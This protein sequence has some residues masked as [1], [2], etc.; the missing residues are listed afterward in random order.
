MSS[1]RL[2]NYSFT[3]EQKNEYFEKG[4]TSI[5]NGVSSNLLNRLQLMAE[6][7]EKKILDKYNK[8]IETPNA[9]ILENKLIRYNSIIKED[10]DTTLELLSSPAMMA[11]FRDICGKGAVPLIMDLLYKHPL[12][13]S[14]VLWHQD[15]PHSR[16]YPY[17]N[18]GIYLDDAKKDD[19][20]LL[21]VPNTQNKKQN[22][23]DIVQKFGWNIPHTVEF[24]AEAGDINIHDMMILHGSKPKKTQN[25]RRT[26]YVE[27]RPYDA[28][29][30]DNLQSKEWADLRK[31]F[32]GLV[33]R[34]ADSS[35]WPSEW[36][37]DYPDDL[38]SDKEEILNILE[39]RE[40]VIAANYAFPPVEMKNYPIP[41]NYKEL[42]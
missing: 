3:E 42:V 5:K 25:P 29:I 2:T 27:I 12:K 32:M 34:R 4:F 18:V 26:I 17:I 22:I 23:H 40:P 16:S 21:Y 35:L 13:G 8:G 11:V 20:C 14:V 24:P 31:R 10:Y 7:F 6:N 41:E 39:I 28:I 9:C 38:K 1:Q 30:E 33:L 19:G 36:K 15:A 37:K